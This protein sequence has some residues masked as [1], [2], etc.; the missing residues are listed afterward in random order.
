MARMDKAMDVHERERFDEEMRLK[1]VKL[2]EAATGAHDL[3]T[4]DE[5]HEWRKCRRCL[6]IQELDTK[7]GHALMLV[8]LKH[9]RRSK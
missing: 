9:L 2:F 5:N 3:V 8:A 6:A 1:A 4:R 7:I